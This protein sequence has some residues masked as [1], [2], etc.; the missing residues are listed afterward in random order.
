MLRKSK[1]KNGTTPSRASLK[2]KVSNTDE[3]L[4]VLSEIDGR[5]SNKSVHYRHTTV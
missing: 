5:Q 1:R 2:N 4:I 3:R